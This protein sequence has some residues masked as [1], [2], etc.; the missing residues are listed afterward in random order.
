MLPKCHHS[1][2]SIHEDRRYLQF[3]VKKRVKSTE[4]HTALYTI[5]HNYIKHTI[6]NIS[7]LRE[8]ILTQDSVLETL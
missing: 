8:W 5:T 3:C 2:K 4:I 1:S 7:G 6:E